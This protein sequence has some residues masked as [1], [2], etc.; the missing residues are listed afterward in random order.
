MKYA[1]RAAHQQEFPVIGMC[2]VLNVSRSVG[3]MLGANENQA[4]ENGKMSP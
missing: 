4:S 1:F 2:Q 3:M